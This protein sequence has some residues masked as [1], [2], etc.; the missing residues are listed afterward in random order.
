MISR[1]LPRKRLWVEELEP[2]VVLS[3][4]P[5]IVPSLISHATIATQS[6]NWSGYAVETDLNAPQNHVFTAVSGTWTVPAVTGSGTAYASIWVGLD[7]YTS[8]TVEQIGTDSDIVNGTAEY[9]AWYEMYPRDSVNI[10]KVKLAVNATDSVTASVTYGS[11]KFTLQITNNTTNQVFSTTQTAV[12]AQRSSAEWIVEAPSSYAG[13]LPLANFGTATIS[14]AAAAITTTTNQVA[15]TTAGPI[16]SPAWQNAS[17]DIVTSRGVAEAKTA[18]LLPDSTVNGAT[19]SSFTVT[20]VA[21]ATSPPP[22]HHHWWW[23]WYS[24]VALSQGDATNTFSAVNMANTN[25]SMGNANVSVAAFAAAALP[26]G[27]SLESR[28]VTRGT[29]AASY[30]MPMFG[31]GDSVAPDVDEVML[32]RIQVP[33]APAML[34]TPNRAN[35]PVVVPAAPPGAMLMINDQARVIFSVEPPA[36]ADVPSE[37]REARSAGTAK[38]WIGVVG[39]LAIFNGE[40][41]LE[42]PR[43]AD[44]RNRSDAE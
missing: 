21:P 33:M 24:P 42:R 23:W 4:V 41:L 18:A 19:T 31:G 34:P 9:Y 35:P 20:D 40:L 44:E 22:R 37:M 25:V 1:R 3:T 16:D 5:S 13:V 28:N 11:G 38:A 39:A 30:P 10:S 29:V 14:N 2:R 36:S 8:S 43:R 6:T 32:P 7:G 17:I 12:R 26:F 15:T 27:V